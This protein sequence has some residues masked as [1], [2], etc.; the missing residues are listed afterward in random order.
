MQLVVGVAVRKQDLN[1]VFTKLGLYDEFSAL[2]SIPNEYIKIL[3]FLKTVLILKSNN[4]RDQNLHL[5]NYSNNNLVML[6]SASA[7]KLMTGN[8]SIIPLYWWNHLHY[9]TYIKEML[10]CIVNRPSV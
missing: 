2:S 5:H 1:F 3:N 8:Q 7:L 4:G 9:S 6:T 10:L